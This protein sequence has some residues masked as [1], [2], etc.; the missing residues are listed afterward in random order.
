[1]TTKTQASL[2]ELAFHFWDK[3]PEEHIT[4]QRISET[5][6][7]LLDAINSYKLEAW[8][9]SKR[10]IDI[11]VFEANANDAGDTEPSSY[12]LRFLAMG[13]PFSIV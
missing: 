3:K 5:L 12:T 10:I 13:Y 2:H 8:H 7:W 9:E 6:F 11:N 1:M 4:N